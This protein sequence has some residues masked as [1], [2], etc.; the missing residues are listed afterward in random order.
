MANNHRSI[1]IRA[2]DFDKPWQVSRI[3]GK[4][5]K[6]AICSGKTWKKMTAHSRKKAM[7]RENKVRDWE[8]IE[9]ITEGDWED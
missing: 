2:S 5:C 9:P 6:C 8:V 1:L 3:I 7:R 4:Y